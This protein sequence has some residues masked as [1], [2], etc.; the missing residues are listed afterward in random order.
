MAS[1]SSTRA[2]K[3]LVIRPARLN[4]LER[5][6][7]IEVEAFGDE[8]YSR[9]L[10]KMYYFVSPETFL[11]ADID[12]EIAGYVIGLYKRWGEGHVISLAVRSKYRRRG[13]ATALM[14]RVIQ[15]L[16]SK[17]ATAIRLEV[18]A[19]NEP[20]INLYKKLG[21]KIIG[22]IDGY[23]RSGESAY[24]MVKKIENP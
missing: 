13:V 21:F 5:V 20:A 1:D 12:G 2:V 17:G 15:L 3:G 14:K 19:S 24:L 16:A 7:E 23:Y 4:D 11:V 10:L 18:K 6:Y 22:V 9:E 8:A